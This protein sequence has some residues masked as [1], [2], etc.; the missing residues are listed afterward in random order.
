[1]KHS[2][3]AERAAEVQRAKT[4]N[5]EW[6]R[7]NRTQDYYRLCEVVPHSPSRVAITKYLLERGFF[8]DNLPREADMVLE[9]ADD[10]GAAAAATTSAAT[11][12]PDEAD[13][14]LSSSAEDVGATD[15]SWQK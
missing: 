5:R 3:P 6:V 10:G 4:S 1:M 12:S 7:S 8:V 13:F 11:A 9:S 2:T 15:P 14:T